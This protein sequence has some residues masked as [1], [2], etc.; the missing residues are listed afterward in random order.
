M[1]VLRFTHFFQHVL[2]TPPCGTITL[3]PSSI[4]NIEIGV[5]YSQTITASGGVAPY[6]YAVSSGSL[7]TGLSLNTNTGLISG[8]PTT[9]QSVSFTIEA[10]DD[11]GCTGSQGYSFSVDYDTDAAAFITAANITDNT[12]KSAINTLV[13]DMKGYGIW[14]KMKAIYPFVGGTATTHKFNL[15]NPLDTNAAFRLIFSGGWTHSVNGAL[16]NGT[17]AYADTFLTPLNNLLLNSTHLSYYSRT[18]IIGPQVEIG[19]VAS[20]VPMT[21][22]IYNYNGIAYKALNRVENI[23]GTTFNPTNGLLIGS[24]ISSTTEKY[25]HKGVLTNTITANSQAP[26]NSFKIFLGCYSN[27]NNPSWFSSKQVAFASIGDG[28]LDSEA[29]NLYLCV[30][31]FNTTLGRQV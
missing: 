20:N 13:N 16:P 18:N 19:V 14:T 2:D 6:T 21:Y 17:N 31:Q 26:N 24:R 22:L 9:Q 5:A 23:V 15:I 7:P 29:N 1:S 25:Y 10:T 28:L 12:Q 3:S 27:G 30:Q 11:D 8:T 4:S